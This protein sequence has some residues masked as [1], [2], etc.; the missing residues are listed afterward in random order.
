MKYKLPSFLYV[1][2]VILFVA[3][4]LSLLFLENVTTAVIFTVLIA[5]HFGEVYIMN[6]YYA[7]SIG[8]CNN[9]VFGVIDR[10][11]VLL[12]LLFMSIHG[13]LAI[14]VFVLLVAFEIVMFLYDSLDMV[15]GKHCKFTLGINVLYNILIYAGIICFLLS[16]VRAGVYVLFASSLCS[17]IYIIASSVM[18]TQEKEV[19]MENSEDSV[20][21][22]EE[23][24]LDAEQEQREI[25]E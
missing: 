24:V 4:L 22:I 21:T 11:I 20:K 10:V 12:P 15:D 7:K 17:A 9:I 18:F 3:V 13:V 14:W 19:L 6:K 16:K 25:I 1:T 2:R 23:Q 5:V 8:S